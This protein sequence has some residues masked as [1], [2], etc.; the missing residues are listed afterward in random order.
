MN[1]V[2]VDKLGAPFLKKRGKKTMRTT[3]AQAVL[4][5]FD[6]LK[7]T[8]YIKKCDIMNDLEISELCFWRYIQELKAY[9]YNFNR[10]YELVYSKSDD[11]YFLIGK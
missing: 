9:I 8:G 2:A 1:N 5:I 3:K 7:E 11:K 6:T 10:S 4:Y